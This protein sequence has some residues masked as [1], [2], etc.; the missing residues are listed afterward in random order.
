MLGHEW[1]E[2]YSVLLYIYAHFI[3]PACLFFLIYIPTTYSCLHACHISLHL[4]LIYIYIYMYIYV[5]MYVAIHTN[6][7][8]HA[9]QWYMCGIW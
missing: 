4:V 3:Y 6:V 9:E 1:Y 5:Y 8:H 7:M 2:W